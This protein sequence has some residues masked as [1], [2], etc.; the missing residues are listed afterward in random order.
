MDLKVEYITQNIKH[1]DSRHSLVLE[2]YRSIT[3][4]PKAEAKFL[5]MLPDLSYARLSQK[6]RIRKFSLTGN[7]QTFLTKYP[8]TAYL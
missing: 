7:Y 1:C 8:I 2:L 6:K 4:T 5:S 3:L